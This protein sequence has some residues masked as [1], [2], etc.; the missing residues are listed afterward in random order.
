MHFNQ[1]IAS[2][3]STGIVFP[4]SRDTMKVRA[5]MPAGFEWDSMTLVAC[6]PFSFSGGP[7]LRTYVFIDQMNFEIAVNDLCRE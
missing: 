1:K 4:Q 7:M 3:L 5:A 2:W 6:Y